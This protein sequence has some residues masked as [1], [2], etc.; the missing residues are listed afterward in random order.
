MRGQEPLPEW[1]HA[2]LKR[3]LPI[4]CSLSPQD[5]T[6]VEELGHHEPA[7]ASVETVPRPLSAKVCPNMPY[8]REAIG[9]TIRGDLCEACPA[10]SSQEQEEHCIRITQVQLFPPPLRLLS[11]TRR[12]SMPSQQLKR[13]TLTRGLRKR[14]EKNSELRILVKTAENVASSRLVINIMSLGKSLLRSFWLRS[15]GLWSVFTTRLVIKAKQQ[16]YRLTS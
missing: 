16:S 10:D 14:P 6:Y 2:P 5:A 4:W 8:V 15:C 12:G 3:H 13:L 1:A 9:A 11:P 7:P